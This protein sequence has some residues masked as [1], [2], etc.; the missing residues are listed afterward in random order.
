MFMFIID[1]NQQSQISTFSNVQNFL[2]HGF[3]YIY[4]L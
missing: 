3:V 2:N 1:F 4:W